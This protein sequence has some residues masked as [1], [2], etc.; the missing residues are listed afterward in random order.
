MSVTFYTTNHFW[1]H[2]LYYEVTKRV[3]FIGNERHY[4]KWYNISDS[5]YRKQRY[6]NPPPE[7][8]SW[9]RF[10]SEVD[11]ELPFYKFFPSCLNI[12][13]TLGPP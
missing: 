13:D 6:R 8:V 5:N 10:H 3:Y 7:A 2:Y 4:H 9:K 1:H 11:N 12:N